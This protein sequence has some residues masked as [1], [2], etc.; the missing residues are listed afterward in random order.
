LQ[1][2]GRKVFTGTP[3]DLLWRDGRPLIKGDEGRSEVGLIVRFYQGEWLSQLPRWHHARELLAM[4]RVPVVNPTRAILT[5]SKRF[6]L[7]WDALGVALPTW[8]ALL[9]ETRDPRDVRWQADDAWIAKPVFGNT[10]DNVLIR[11]LMTAERWRQGIKNVLR[12]REQWVAQ[13]RF[14]I[15]PIDSP[16][17]PLLPCIGV[18]TIDGKAAGCYGRVTSGG[19]IDYCA[20]DVAILI[21]EGSVADDEG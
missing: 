19:W 3:R 10:G 20:Q 8:R 13:R 16:K 11:Q 6:P 15:V 17:G 2:K 9:P 21:A 4:A 5:E 12:K 14:E 1:A 18:Y 7:V